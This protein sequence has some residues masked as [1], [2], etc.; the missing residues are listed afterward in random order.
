[1]CDR[2]SFCVDDIKGRTI[3]NKLKLS[4]DKMEEMALWKLPA[5]SRIS[6]DS[7]VSV[8]CQIPFAS[9]KKSFDVILDPALSTK[10]QINTVRRV[11]YF[12]I[13]QIDL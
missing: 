6:R 10:Q 9:K 11:C 12:H 7:I 4:E 5:L 13:R 3:K 1:M 2:L 8:G